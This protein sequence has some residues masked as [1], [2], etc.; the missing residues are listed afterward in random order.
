MDDFK[1]QNWGAASNSGQGQGGPS[2]PPPPP[3]PEITLRTM[4]SDI[5]S[6]KQSGGENPIPK[7]FIPPEIKKQNNMELEDLSK[8]ESM[9]KPGNGDG[10]LPPSEPP[11]KKLKI[12]ILITIL[13]LVIAGAA[14]AG[15][16]FIYPMFKPVI[17]MPVEQPAVIPENLPIVETIPPVSE[18][19]PPIIEELATTTSPEVIPIPE[20]IVLK[21]H[22]SLLVSSADSAVP[23]VL[24]AP[25][26]LVSIRE[27]LV[28]EA[29]NKPSTEMALKEI[30]LSDQ[31]GQLVFADI[32]PLFLPSFT[33]AELAPLFEEDFTSVIFYDSNG[34]WFGMI[35]KPKADIDIADAKIL[36]AKLEMSAD[37][38]NLYIQSPGTQVTT[39]FKD[40]KANNLP[41]RYLNF[42]KTGASLDYG[43]TSNNLLVISTSYNGVKAMLTKLGVQ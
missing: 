43:W 16:K 4:Q 29:V 6:I 22:M 31:G 42:S 13:I 9:I 3:P 19:A 21:S 37:L 39:E 7:P 17:S 26:S 2:M 8:E 23:F 27:F 35:A 25:A 33:S 38:A 32:L 18:L 36:M 11:K 12:F 20:P 15:Y 40:G 30:V 1:Q 14:F 5:E 34:A 24:S 28:A 41:V 10:V